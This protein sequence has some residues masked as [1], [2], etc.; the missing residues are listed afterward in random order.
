MFIS[1]S[2]LQEQVN[3]SWHSSGYANSLDSDKKPTLP[4]PTLPTYPQQPP[5]HEITDSSGIIQIKLESPPIPSN[6]PSKTTQKPSKLLKRSPQSVNPQKPPPNLPH[7]HTKISTQA[8]E[9]K[10]PWAT[11]EY[12][13]YEGNTNTDS[14]TFWHKSPSKN[15]PALWEANGEILNPE[16]QLGAKRAEQKTRDRKR[17]RDE[18]GSGYAYKSRV[19]KERTRVRSVSKQK[20][21]RDGK[22]SKKKHGYN[23]HSNTS[24]IHSLISTDK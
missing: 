11:K 19:G 22:K 13:K 20:K 6:Q 24:Q 4:V 2:S 14:F 17:K 7:P 9:Y 3:V 5:V 15:K 10:S 23:K 12:E 1:K 21:K 8:Q 18:C 16:E